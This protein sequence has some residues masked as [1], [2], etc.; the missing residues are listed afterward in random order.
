MAERIIGCLCGLLCAF[1]FL[2]LGYTAKMNRDPVSFWNG[3]TS[4]KEKVG[5]VKAY[6]AAMGKLYG[7]YGMA[8][9]LSAVLCAVYPMVG[10]TLLMLTATVGI[11]L[12]YRGYKRILKTCEK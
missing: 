3:D 6:N 5:D 10:F 11:F 1:P 9:L 8:F 7:R 12:V 2:F 4:L